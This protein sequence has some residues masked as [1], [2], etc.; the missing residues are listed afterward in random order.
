MAQSQLVLVYGGR[1][2]VLNLRDL[3]SYNAASRVWASRAAGRFR[4][5]HSAVAI[6]D[7]V[8]MLVFGGLGGDVA[9][10]TQARLLNQLDA[11]TVASDSWI[12]LA[13]GPSARSEHTAVVYKQ[14]MFVFG[15]ITTLPDGA[16]NELW[17]FDLATQRWTD[18]TSQTTGDVPLPL[19]GHTAS[20]VGNSMIVM[21]G[22]RQV[23][24]ELQEGNVCRDN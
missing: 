11:Y 5:S 22:F 2:E 1:N 7:G 19:W 6:N 4:M 20:V 15:G 23:Q 17:R 8:Q 12:Q 24:F 10:V 21:F 18:L 3:S 9:D 14:Q 13:S 16:T